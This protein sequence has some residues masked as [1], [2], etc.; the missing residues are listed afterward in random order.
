MR[1]PRAR[2]AGV[3]LLELQVAMI[4]LGVAVTGFCPLVVMQ[5]R[6]AR[7]LET[8][9][10]GPDNPQVIRGVRMLDGSPF[11]GQGFAAAPPATVLQPQPDGWVR[12]LGLAASFAVNAPAQP[13][14]PLPVQTV[15]D[16]DAGSGFSAS[17]WANAKDTSANDDDY[18]SL[19]VDSAS[20]PATWTFS[21]LVPGRY[22]VMTSWVPKAQNA[23]DATYLFTDASDDPVAIP[24]DQT[25]G[26]G[27]SPPWADLGVYY[28]DA[29]FQVT[30]PGSTSGTVIADAIQLVPAGALNSVTITTPAATTADGATVRVRVT[31]Q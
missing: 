22:H 30:L 3:S 2:R 18:H 24:V 15:L 20:G 31:G 19:A 27:G 21:G 7:K 9:P 5:A 25:A 6:L 12:R 23:K 10:V 11:S 4:V 1:P 13:F 26:P 29:T 16:D 8:Q 17:G 28:L 14:T